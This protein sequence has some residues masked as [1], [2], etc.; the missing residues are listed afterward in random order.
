MTS[1]VSVSV[2]LPAYNEFSTITS[3]VEDTLNRLKTFL[4]DGSYELI[5]A[6]DGCTDSTPQIASDLANKYD[7]V[8]HYHSSSRLGRGEAL[9]RAFE[10]ANGET[11]VYLDTDLATDNAHL[12][13]L[14]NAVHS[15]SADIATGSRWFPGTQTK[16]PFH[17]S[18]LSK[19]FN[20]LVRFLLK[21]KLYD[22]QCGFKA[23]NKKTFFKL[24]PSLKDTHW[25]W[26]TEILVKAQKSNFNV[27][28]FPVSWTA[29][30]DTKVDIIRDV[31][32]M[33][34]NILR[35]WV[36]FYISPHIT[37]AKS[38]IFGFSIS[39]LA[40]L[41]MGYYLD[42]DLN[43]FYIFIS[44][45]LYLFFS[46]FVYL[47]SWPLRGIRY[48]EILSQLGFSEP[49]LFLT[50]AIFVSQTCNLVIPARAGDAARAYILKT[51][52]KIPYVSGFASLFFERLFDLLTITT[53]AGVVF[54]LTHI[55]GKGSFFSTNTGLDKI[56][57]SGEIALQL[58]IFVGIAVLSL[59][60]LILLTSKT[61]SNSV[62]RFLQFFSND[63]YVQRLSSYLENFIENIQKLTINPIIFAR[64]GLLSLLI[65]SLD[66]SVAIIILYSFS[67]SLPLTTL[68]F[69]C[70]FAVSIGNLAKVLPLSP[71]G[72]GLYEGAFT[73]LV[74]SLTGISPSLAL[75]VAILDHAIKNIVTILGG[76]FSSIDLNLSLKNTLQNK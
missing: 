50:E 19:G 18:I 45:P 31:F 67:P 46:L 5:I 63:L 36:E 15:G 14:I 56:N 34:I 26:D 71:G 33:A 37:P 39:L 43:F 10:I 54:M 75:G 32:A 17:R 21:S 65:W 2:V 68:I 3:A 41:L 76:L 55:L 72:I 4:P 49:L 52:K 25:F 47:L 62:S 53:L 38:S 57:Q 64:V 51:K 48:R 11:L 66:V 20:T 16:R 1:P 13:Q 22:H 9:N 30:K 7:E 8:I 6:E 59:L 12:E 44:N 73:L 35:L 61:K 29:Q 24:S 40:L 60:I 74:V 70:F 58:A 42:L 28:E 27:F 23:F 69:T